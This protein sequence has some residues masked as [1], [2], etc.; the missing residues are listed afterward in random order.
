M[1]TTKECASGELS[2]RLVSVGTNQSGVRKCSERDFTGDRE[3]G[4]HS[5]PREIEIDPFSGLSV[6]GSSVES[7][8]SHFGSSR[9]N[10]KESKQCSEIIFE[11][12]K[13]DKEVLRENNGTPSVLFDNRSVVESQIKRHKQV[14]AQIS[15][16]QA[17]GQVSDAET[18]TESSIVSMEQNESVSEENQAESWASD[19]HSSYGRLQVG[20]GG[21][22]GRTDNV[23]EMVSSNEQVSYQLP[24]TSS[25][26]LS[27]EKIQSASRVSHQISDGQ[28]D[29]SG[30]H[31]KGGG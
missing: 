1:L 23:R 18:Q 21:S 28:F 26:G 19:T 29:S 17:K 9:Q 4:V 16:Q 12:E 3:K 31:N 8:G 15:L 7:G 11:K 2:R 5:E 24:G 27:P 6:V 10:E 30:L 25:S 13:S 14:L 20:L 22:F